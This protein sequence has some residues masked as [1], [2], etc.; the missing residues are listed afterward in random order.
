MKNAKQNSG[1]L[2][3]LIELLVVIAIIAILAGMLLPALNKARE[4][5]RTSECLNRKKQVMMGQHL[6]AN[7]SHDFMI[8]WMNKNSFARILTGE[9]K[10][11]GTYKYVD[12]TQPYVSWLVM[13]CTSLEVP[14]SLDDNN[15]RPDWS[16]SKGKDVDT[17]GTIGV[18]YQYTAN[19]LAKKY[20]KF[21]FYDTTNGYEM[22]QVFSSSAAKSASSI[23]LLGDSTYDDWGNAGANYIDYANASKRPSLVE[24]HGGKATG[25][26]M[27]GHCS[28]FSCRDLR[29]DEF[30]MHNYF[31]SGFESIVF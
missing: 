15:L 23:L 30:P 28:A 12:Q 17:A 24:V 10:T 18:I 11:S 8:G 25:G 7:D 31:S 16:T 3:T 13:T 5:A 9:G 4:A 2:F 26:F 19:E 21:H 6:Y 22:M 27:D 20:G 1:S 14:R 29:T